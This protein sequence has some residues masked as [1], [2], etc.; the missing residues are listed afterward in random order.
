MYSYAYM[1]LISVCVFF[2]FQA[3][4]G[5]R[6]YK[7]TGVQT[8]ALPI[9]PKL[10]PHRPLTDLRERLDPQCC[11]TS[12]CRDRRRGYA[13]D[14]RAV[15]S[16]RR[17]IRHRDRWRMERHAMDSSSPWLPATPWLALVRSSRHTDLPPVETVRVRSE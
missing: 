2:F 1:S 14:E 15:R 16:D 3:E 10:P 13:R 6:D 12:V 4:D 5:I 8:C 7:V 9:W 11:G 17:G